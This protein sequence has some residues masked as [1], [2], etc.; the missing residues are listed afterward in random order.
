MHEQQSKVYQLRIWLKEISPMVW[1]RLLI[2]DTYTIADLHYCLQISFA[3][4]D[5]HLHQFIIYGKA[6]GLYY[7]GGMHFSDDA[8]QVYLDQFQLRLNERFIYQYNFNDDW[9]YELRLEKILPINTKYEYPLCSAGN[10]TAPPEDCGGPEAF[11]ALLEQNQSHYSLE[12]RLLDL[13]ED[14][15]N[16]EKDL[17]DFREE[18]EDLRFWA[19]AY[20][21]DKK[22]TNRK[23]KKYFSNANRCD[24]SIE[25]VIDEY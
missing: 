6:Y 16:G 18:V 4:S 21:F 22:S 23:L 3:W 24:I 7:A 20:K 12:W 5:S 14:Y 15:K 9:E 8:N 13:V 17:G 19:T 11:M 25:E 1:R 10:R 2:K